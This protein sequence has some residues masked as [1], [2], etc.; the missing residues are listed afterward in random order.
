MKNYEPKEFE[1]KIYEFWTKSGYFRANVNPD[2][3]PFTIIMPPPNITGQLHMGHALNNTIQDVLTRYKRM[4]G[5]EALWLSGT[6]HASIATEVKI[7][8]KLL[9]EG[10]S[11]EQLG[12]EKFL[13][14]A[15]QWND[16]FGG[17]IIE[18]LKKLGSSCDWERHAFTMDEPRSK[19]VKD[20]F[21][22]LYE[23]GLIY[24]GNRI[25]NWCPECKTALSDAEVEHEPNEGSLWHI[26][27]PLKDGSDFITVATTR[28]ETMLGDVAVCVN[29]KDKRYSKLIGRELSL[30][31]TERSIPVISDNY[32]DK[33]F[34]TGAVK[35]TPYHDPNDFEIGLRHNLEPICVMNED[36]T[37]NYGE[38]KGVDRFD[39]RKR[40]VRALDTLGLLIKVEK[41]QNNVGT[42]YRCST[43]IEPMISKQWFVKMQPLAEPA[44]D[45]VKKGQ[46]KFVPK[47]FEKTY[48]HWMENIKDWCISRQLWWGHR[49]PAYHCLEC[50]KMTVSAN[51]VEKCPSCNG[52]VRQDADVLDTWFSS[53]LFPFSTLGYP[54]K[55]EELK[56]FYPTDVL[57]TGYDIIF[58]WVARMIFSSLEFMGEAPF[59]TVYINGLVRDEHGK[60]MSKSAGNGVD[61]LELI[62]K[63][64]AD[65][66]RFSL[67]H[68][69]SAGGDTRI[70]YD[71]LEGYRNFMNKIVNASKFVAMHSEKAEKS[72]DEKMLS[73]ADKWILTKL[74]LTISEMTKHMDKFDIGLASSKLYEFVWNDFCDWYIELTK[75]NLNASVLLFVFRSILKLAHPFIPYLTEELYQRLPHNCHESIMISDY[76]EQMK[77]FKKEYVGFEEVMSMVKGVRNL[78]SELNVPPSKKAKIYVLPEKGS[79]KL[80]KSSMP[81]IEKLCQGDGIEFKKP[82]GKCSELITNI[83][84]VYLLTNDLVDT[85]KEKERLQNE[86]TK[87]TGEIKRAEGMLNNVGF[88][89]RAPE[90]KIEE[91]KQKLQK[92]IDLKAKIEK[93]LS[94]I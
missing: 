66:L 74:N 30:P 90:S 38:Y 68:G 62:D 53:A 80:L 92:Y 19:A 57:V 27:Y 43:V 13:E 26:K 25:I 93:S 45:C 10:T 9:E 84:A 6:D 94:E 12:R 8:D 16:E 5:F 11:K 55:T 44:I 83:G 28:P 18:Q 1:N 29:P 86:L 75:A 87:V 3:K 56:Y 52:G 91:E 7:I 23:K 71:K 58:F 2:K 65:T 78:R 17:R 24:Q 34:G 48:F 50:E 61:P 46:T 89:S 35:I 82:D 49:I 20:V 63:Y 59:H 42:C 4:K 32:V 39:A 79:E 64:G 33:S 51:D 21:V 76:P 37:M 41:H 54:E 69:I 22:K 14:R 88:T 81:Y 72:F 60:K 36:G 67:V 47:R 70:Q 77:S 31:L 85:T 40:I 15:Y 73:I